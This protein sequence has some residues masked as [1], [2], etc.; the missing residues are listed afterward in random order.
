[1]QMANRRANWL[2]FAPMPRRYAAKQANAAA[3][4]D[5][6]FMFGMHKRTTL[7]LV[8]DD[9]VL[10]PVTL[11]MLK[12]MGHRAKLACCV[13]E[14]FEILTRPNRI[15]LVVLDLQLGADRGEQLVERV[16]R[17]TSAPPILILSALPMTDLQQAANEIG[18]HAVLQ[19]PCSLD[20]MTHAIERVLA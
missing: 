19:K 12:L 17:V 2:A 11:E 1:M 4:L 5:R 8:E 13:D 20:Q 9:P 6:C 7:L 10:G 14:A 16:R 18:A 3:W 15:E